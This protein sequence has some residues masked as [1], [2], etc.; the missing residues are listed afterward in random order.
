MDRLTPILGFDFLKSILR[1]LGIYGSG[2]MDDDGVEWRKWEETILGFD[3]LKSI[4][5]ALGIYG[6]GRMDDDGVEWRKWEETGA[7]Q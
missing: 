6:S 1:A 7:P 2:R 5:R 3:F 4:L